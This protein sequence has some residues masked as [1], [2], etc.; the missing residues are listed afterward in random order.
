MSSA[1]TRAG[2]GGTGRRMP[3]AIN[4]GRWDELGL[5]LLSAIVLGTA[6]LFVVYLGGLAF[7][8]TLVFF[9]LIMVY[10]WDQ[11]CEERHFG[12]NGIAHGIFT[13]GALFLVGAGLVGPALVVLL[14]GAASVAALALFLGR[15]VIW[16]VL[17]LVYVAL[18]CATAIWLREQGAHGM[19]VVLWSLVIVWATDTGAYLFGKSIGGSRLAPRI[20]P[21]KTWAGLIG[22]TACGTL[23]GGAFA[24]ITGLASIVI[25]AGLSFILTFAAH[26]GDLAE[27]AIK[28]HFQVKDSG[29]LIPGHGGILDRVDGLV[30]VWPVMVVLSLLH[31]G[32]ILPWTSQ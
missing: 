25:L 31:G 16:P 11:L 15:P 12:P 5:R 28:R 13:C 22:G 1:I 17:G 9:A 7:S 18:P 6:V 30:F 27:S 24:A 14:A 4:A 29:T 26:A 2:N 19:S 3:D 8:A 32:A 10:E 20:S 21:K 23:A